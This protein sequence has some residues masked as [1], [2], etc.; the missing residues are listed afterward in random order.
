MC[1]KIWFTL[2]GCW[3]LKSSKWSSIIFISLETRVLHVCDKYILV[4]DIWEHFVWNCF[5][6]YF[7]P[8]IL[9]QMQFFFFK[10]FSAS[11]QLV[12]FKCFSA[13]SSTNFHSTKGRKKNSFSFCFWS[14]FVLHDKT[15][16][17]EPE[18]HPLLEYYLIIH[19]LTLF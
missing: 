1:R 13:S 12:F 5:F 10:C 3:L 16:L 9:W 2:L 7:K 4:I 6:F 17:L 14:L 15:K 8:L 19:S 11:S 18:W